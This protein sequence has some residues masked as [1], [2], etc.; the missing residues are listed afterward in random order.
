MQRVACQLLCSLAVSWGSQEGAPAGDVRARTGGADSGDAFACGTG[1]DAPGECDALR[2]PDMAAGLEHADAAAGQARGGRSKEREIP[3]GADRIARLSLVFVMFGSLI[4]WIGLLIKYM[5]DGSLPA[6]L[7]LWGLMPEVC[8]AISPRSIVA[9]LR[10]KKEPTPVIVLRG[11]VNDAGA[12][13]LARGVI[14]FGPKAE[15]QVIELPHNPSLTSAGLRRLVAA[16]REDGVQVSELDLSSNPQLCSTL[17]ADLQ[18]A[19]MAKKNALQVLKVADCDLVATGLPTL[20]ELIALSQ[21]R[22]LDLSYNN[23][24]GGGEALASAMDAPMLQELVLTCCSLGV[25]E[26]EAIADQLPFTSIKSLQVGGNRFG[27]EGLAVIADKLPASQVQELGLEANE[28]SSA[29]FGCLGA[30]WAKRPF[31]QLRLAGNNMSQDEVAS[32]IRTLK[33]IHS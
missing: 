1:D 31:S 22:S 19:L 18:P 25:P 23:F 33:S 10:M 12:E 30:A 15:L 32:F 9:L 20:T 3:D 28:L 14:E 21:L 24:K 13:E 4:T 7:A 6:R 29:S 27:N 5:I 11:C 17:P 2:A 26:V 8:A 16:T